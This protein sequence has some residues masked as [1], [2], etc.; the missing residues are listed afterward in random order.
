[1][2]ITFMKTRKEAVQYFLPILAGILTGGILL[3]DVPLKWE[4]GLLTALGTAV[5]IMIFGIPNRI[6]LFML[7]FTTSFNVGKS[8]I[9]RPEH[10]GLSMGVD[11]KLI[12]LLALV[13]LLFYLAKG[14]PRLSEIRFFPM[15]TIPAVAWLVFSSLSLLAARDGELVV[16]QLINMAKLLFL[17][18]IIANSVK[19]DVDVK[20]LIAGLMLGLLL[21]ALIGAYQGISG[22]PLGL[23]FLDEIADVK[24]QELSVGLANRVQGTIGHP[25]SYAMYLVMVIPFTLASL[26][27]RIKHSFKVLAG[28]MLCLSCVALIFTLARMAWINFLVIISIVLML[29]VRRKRISSRAVIWIVGAGSLI[30]LGLILFGPDIILSRLTS[31]DQGSAYSRFTLARTALAIIKDHPFVGVGLNN[32]SLVSTQYGATVIGPQFVVHNA[33]LLI[34]AETGLVGLAAFLSFLATLLIQAWRIIVQA[35]NDIVW[36]V[37][38]GIFSAFIAFAT[39]GMVDYAMLSSPQVITQFWLLAGMSAALIQ[40]ID[41][42][43]RHSMRIT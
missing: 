27:S 12:D 30:L 43:E 37:G 15:I 34:A 8:L 25:N 13:L 16:M 4:I 32:Y 7:A 38:V 36:I 17:C 40:R 33:Y 21:Q 23:F 20:F 29:A 22:R 31:S 26:F 11:I 1:M 24:K 6:I 10:L 19:N 28:I 2:T 3:L 14:A 5:L 39:H 42:D 18:W 41:K 9:S 35:P